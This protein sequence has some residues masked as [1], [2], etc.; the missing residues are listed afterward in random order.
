MGK[1]Q[2]KRTKINWEPIE[3]EYRAGTYSDAELARRHGCSRTAIQ[4]RVAKEGWKRDLARQV[5]DA[6]NSKMLKIDAGVADCVATCNVQE[7]IDKASD[8]RASVQVCHRKDIRNGREIVAILS[9]QLRETALER[10]QINESIDAET[11][12]GDGKID[13]RK[14]AQMKRAVALPANAATARDLTTALKNL[15]ALERQAFNID[16]SASETTDPIADILTEVAKRKQS[17][18]NEGDQ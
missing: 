2:K 6:T 12:S 9:S 7:T 18:V 3:G 11:E 8:T 16:A 4:K 14:R 17:L 13:H 10:E 15:V 1:E 5:R